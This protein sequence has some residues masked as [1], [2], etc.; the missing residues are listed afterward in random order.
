MACPQPGAAAGRPRH[1]RFCDTHALPA[2]VATLTCWRGVLP[3]NF[4]CTVAGPVAAAAPRTLRQRQ[5]FSTQHQPAQ[6]RSGSWDNPLDSNAALS[7][8]S[9]AGTAGRASAPAARSAVGAL[10]GAVERC[11]C[12]PAA[13]PAAAGGL[14]E[15]WRSAKWRSYRALLFLM[16]AGEG[17]AAGRG[18]CE[19]QAALGGAAAVA[20]GL[21]RSRISRQCIK[22]DRRAFGACA[23]RLWTRWRR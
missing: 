13:T 14:Q 4:A 20:C 18:D 6:Q 9:A 11:R 23:P 7:A 3:A 22:A 16:P 1:H 21:K 19:T 2:D 15:G 8:S 12:C 17:G 5:R 10:A